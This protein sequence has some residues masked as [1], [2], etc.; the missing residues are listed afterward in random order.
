M[1]T[2]YLNVNGGQTALCAIL[3][4]FF[5]PV[6]RVKV[7]KVVSAVDAAVLPW[8]HGLMNGSYLFLLISVVFY[9]LVKT[10]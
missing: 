3:I 5:L 2:C 7:V 4:L 8:F 1:F 6:H 10:V 9:A